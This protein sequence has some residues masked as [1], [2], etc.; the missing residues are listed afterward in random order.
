MNIRPYR[1][2]DRGTVIA[3]WNDIFSDT[4]RFPGAHNDPGQAIDRKQAVADE[5]FLVA[6]EADTV[7]GTVLGGYDGHRGWVYS[8]AVAPDFQRRG[9][10]GAL[11]GR[12]EKKLHARGCPKVNL[13][14][15]AGNDSVVSFYKKLG[16]DIEERISMGKRM[17]A[18][19]EE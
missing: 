5:L 18:Q 15:R 6:V 16:Y 19:S 12:V 10:G 2:S 7:I 8:L 4:A 3:L 17:Q 9:I 11:M 1:N 13:Q 14:V